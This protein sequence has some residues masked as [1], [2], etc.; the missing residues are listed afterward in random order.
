MPDGVK[1]PDQEHN[2]HLIADFIGIQ[3]YDPVE[4]GRKQYPEYPHDH[5]TDGSHPEDKK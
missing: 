1:Y 3:F 2:D 4:V 5:E